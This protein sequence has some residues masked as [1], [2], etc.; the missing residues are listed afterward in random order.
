[1]RAWSAAA[2]LEI[3]TLVCVSWRFDVGSF[4]LLAFWFASWTMRKGAPLLAVT[5]GG[6]NVTVIRAGIPLRGYGLGF[7]PGGAHA[8]TISGG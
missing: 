8:G 7:S 2:S 3:R 4:L 1:V 6:L 5:L